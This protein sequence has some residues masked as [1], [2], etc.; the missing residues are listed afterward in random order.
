MTGPCESC[1]F[2]QDEEADGVAVQR[3]GY[4]VG[5]VCIEGPVHVATTARHRCGRWRIREDLTGGR[6]A[7]VAVAEVAPR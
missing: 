6:D 1:T 7:R 4:G 3:I 2:W 5:K